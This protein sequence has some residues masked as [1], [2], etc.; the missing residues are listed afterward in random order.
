MAF[1]RKEFLKLAGGTAAG[2]AILS[3][4][5]PNVR[6]FLVQSPSRLP[7]DLVNGIDNWYATSCSQCGSGC[8]VIVRVIEGRAK[9]VEG[10]PVHPLSGGKLCAR[11]QAGVQAVYHPDR[12]RRP[13]KAT[14]ARGS[15]A[16]AETTWDEALAAVTP[17]LNEMKGAA[18]GSLLIV[19]GALNGS[20]GMVA[21]RFAK[22]MN[23][24]HA[25]FEP[26]EEAALK[27]A[28]KQT[29]DQDLLP[30]FD[31]GR[32]NYILSFSSDF[33]GGWISQVR[34]SRGYG[35]FR[36]GARKR[37]TLVQAD[38][39]LSPTAAGADEWVYVKPG[40]EGK[41][42]LSIAYVIIKS[43]LGDAAAARALTG[44]RGAAALEAY[45]PEKVAEATGVSAK[46][47]EELA[48]AF[49]AP[50]N[51]PAIAIGGGA[52][53][54]HTNGVFNLTAIY[55]LNHL[56]GTV[57]KP[58]GVNFNPAPP[59][60]DG[61]AAAD[62][63]AY[64]AGTSTSLAE[65]KKIIEG[66][67]QGKVKALVIRNANAV[68]SLP[69][70]LGFADALA[71]VPTVISLSSFLD[72]TTYWADWVLPTSL[73]LEDWADA[74]MNPG[75]GYE[76]VTFQQPVVRPF[77]DTRGFG[78]I[79]LTLAQ[80]L[81]IE[82]DLPW[83]SMRDAL[84]QQAQK[85]HQFGRGN[86]KAATFEEFWGKLLQQG[87][88]WDTNARALPVPFVNGLNLTNPEP[89][90]AGDAGRYPFVLLPFQT[91]GI[92]D[93]RLAHL[94]WLQ[95]TPDPMTTA[96]WETWVEVNSKT[97]RD[98]DLREGDV[99]RIESPA[100]A[101]QALVYPNPAAPPDVLAIPVGRGHKAFGRW[102]EGYGANVYAVLDPREEKQ[103]G[104]LAWAA[105]RVSIAKTGKWKRIPKMEGSVLP[106]DF[107]NKIKVTNKD[108]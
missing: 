37:G 49:V 81:K 36:Q 10:N 8:G 1:T 53:G 62:R 26:M 94:P 11:G 77:R 104:S 19:T 56:V 82:K 30:D 64:A 73:P 57:N 58:G 61:T 13:M 15:G 34:H 101:I 2:A 71:N 4:C 40:S 103:S 55:S 27:A 33:L 108:S 6:E 91:A 65:W 93:G 17:K 32:S 105:T 90:F 106:I 28:I 67:K 79:L 80:E 54:A 100:G 42:A 99:V 18:A 83:T 68:H 50:E 87:G 78:D 24:T 14:G 31:L 29:F 12:V 52:A 23:A 25:T 107:S 76:A 51:Q 92:G 44:G 41:L 75:P 46:H 96:T 86:I 66:M 9:K 98:M 69:A 72:D 38:T 7:E 97:A 47:I 85:L 5:R 3:A 88:W 63:T 45:A 22:A 16:F 95:A 60:G 70:S 43:G 21:K 39:R 35:E 74:P 59:I 48:K 84:R 102:A 20:Q 89:E